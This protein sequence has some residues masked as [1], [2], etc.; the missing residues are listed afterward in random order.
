MD[1]DQIAEEIT[2][3]IKNN[4]V[5][6]VEKLIGSDAELLNMM[7]PLGTWLHIAASQGNLE[8]VKQLVALGADINVRGGTLNAGAML[9]AAGEGHVKV[10]KYLLSGG[11]EMDVSQPERNPLFAAIY[12]WHVEIAKLLIENGID[13]QIE[14]TVKYFGKDVDALKFAIKQGQKKIAGLLGG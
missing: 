9:E 14:Y 3:A 13:T 2:T 7:T 12:G 5:G 8:I 11:A 6:R 1:N 10:V 4:D